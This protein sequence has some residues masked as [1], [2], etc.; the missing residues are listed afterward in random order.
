[1][2]LEKKIKKLQRDPFQFFLDSKIVKQFSKSSSIS[3][4]SSISN[5][6]EVSEPLIFGSLKIT[7]NNLNL[8]ILSKVVNKNNS[9]SGLTSIILTEKS[10]IYL[11][12]RPYISLMLK[13]KSFFAFKNKTLYFLEETILVKNNFLSM[14]VI[15]K[16]F[17]T[18][19]I[20]RQN[21][22][23]EFRNIISINAMSAS[24]II[25]R[26]TNPNL[27]NIHIVDNNT[28]LNYLEKYKDFIDV[29]IV[30]DGIDI[31][32]YKN[33]PRIIVFK[34]AKSF[35]DAIKMILIDNSYKL[36]SNIL[37]PVITNEDNL[38][39][40]DEYNKRGTEGLIRFKYE[41]NDIK[42]FTDS[43]ENYYIEELY[44]KE[45][46][47]SLYKDM[48]FNIKNQTDLKKLLKTT[49]RDG[50]HYEEI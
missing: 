34:D 50:V 7:E 14:G 3:K 37:L 38:Y 46:I 15:G 25:L 24:S 2:S 6:F 31:E 17:M 30:F 9:L 27:R 12:N 45:S 29:L 4:P 41:L 40:I 10:D 36:E 8:K 49:L 33:I 43:V 16:Y 13:E 47:Y 28:S 26:E 44:L 22:F 20:L 39:G 21:P 18:T 1:M 19:K 48:I 5:I 42:T 11:I 32:N 35:L 23:Q